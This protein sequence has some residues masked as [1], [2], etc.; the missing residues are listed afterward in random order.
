M[1]GAANSDPPGLEGQREL[2]R[3]QSPGSRLQVSGLPG[4]MEVQV[5]E[6]L[7][8]A[9]LFFRYKVKPLGGCR[10]QTLGPMLLSAALARGLRASIA[11]GVLRPQ[12][13]LA[14]G[15]G[16]M[17]GGSCVKV[18]PLGEVNG[19]AKAGLGDRDGG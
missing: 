2:P 11:V 3:A 17:G 5:L 18:L 12:L 10:V 8:L 6:S 14:V 9:V 7:S 19:S 1:W 16:G 15:V 13:H 4:S